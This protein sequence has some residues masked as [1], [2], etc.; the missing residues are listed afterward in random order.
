ML[1]MEFVAAQIETY[2]N[3][4]LY[5]RKIM[6]DDVIKAGTVSIDPDNF[7]IVV[8]TH[9]NL[10]VDEKGKVELVSILKGLDSDETL[11]RVLP[12]TIVA[13]VDQELQRMEEQKERFPLLTMDEENDV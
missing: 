6:F 1:G 3:Q 5:E 10:P 11:L 9:R 2:F 13:N 8:K 7:T 4:G 12:N